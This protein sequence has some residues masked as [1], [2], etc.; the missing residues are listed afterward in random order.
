MSRLNI[1]STVQD[2]AYRYTMPKMSLRQE[3]RLN[4]VKT[5]I[6]NLDDLAGALRVP[7]IVVI[8]YFCAELGASHVS[9]SIMTGDHKYD[10]LLKGLDKFINNYVLCKKC[11][12]PELQYKAEK[13]DL[14]GKCNS[15][16]TIRRLDSNHKAGKQLLK[17]VPTF[18]PTG[19][20]INTNDTAQIGEAL[21]MKKKKGGMIEEEKEEFSGKGKKGK[22]EVAEIPVVE[23]NLSSTEIDKAIKDLDVFILENEPTIDDLLLEVKTTQC[24]LSA[25]PDFKYYILFCGVF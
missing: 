2:P 20:D 17:D 24:S 23:L 16:S 7:E 14:F 19:V 25:T 5:N 12:Y 6:T 13:K 3:S 10:S 18:N 9:G 21:K 1:P 4:G 8:K 22:K 15:C 11:N